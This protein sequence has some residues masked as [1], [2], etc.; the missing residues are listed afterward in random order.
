M[1]NT[2]TNMTV[3]FVEDPDSRTI[4]CWVALGTFDLGPICEQAPT[5]GMT[6]TSLDATEIQEE[7]FDRLCPVCFKAEE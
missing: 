7:W 1:P 2:E 6:F 3:S 5:A 4:H